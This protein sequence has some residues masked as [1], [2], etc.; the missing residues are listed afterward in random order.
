[1]VFLIV[2]HQYIL[3]GKDKEQAI[4]LLKEYNV[5]ISDDIIEEL[6]DEYEKGE[7]VKTDPKKGSTIKE[8]DVVKLTISKGK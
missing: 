2:F 3:E 1:M 7:I 4:E 5:T 6:S 8:G